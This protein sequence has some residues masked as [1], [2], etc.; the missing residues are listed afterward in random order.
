MSRRVPSLDAP[1]RRFVRQYGADL[2]YW[3]QPKGLAV[4]PHGLYV[5]LAVLKEFAHTRAWR[6]CQAD[7]IARLK[8]EK[9]SG[10][11]DNWTSGGA[12]LARMLKQVLAVLGLAW[13]DLNDRVEITEAGEA[14]LSSKDRVGMLSAQVLRY[15]FWNPSVSS[16]THRVVRLHPVPFLVRLLQSVENNITGV[17]YN[18]FVSKAKC[19]S[20][21][22]RVADQIDAFR[23]LSTSE[24]SEIVLQCKGFSIGGT[25]RSSIYNT[26]NL[27]RAYAY[28]MWTLSNLVI[29]GPD[30]GLQ[31]QQAN[32]RGENRKFLDEY[33]ANGVYIDFASQKEFLSWMG[34]PAERPSKQSA[35]EI[36]VNRGDL[37]SATEVKKELGASAAEIRGFKRMM[38]D[39]KTLE[40]NLE[41]NFSSFGKK[42]GMD[43]TLVGRQYATTV[44]PIDLLGQDKRT[45]Q[46]VV[47]ELKKG[48]SADRVFGQLSR[49]MGWVKRYL[50]DGHAVV[51]VIVAA[52]IDDKLR[53]ARDA[54]DSDVRLLEFESKLSVSVV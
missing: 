40:T 7:Y 39:E 3:Y 48:R 8:Q 29:E 35:L 53:S 2:A 4:T 45:K 52:Q 42:L 50:A 49:Y 21:I 37:S 36:Y 41:H 13:I 44:G 18:L 26:I 9:I 14:F 25:G 38:I 54:H 32:L 19:I 15:Q 16:T 28:K 11:E 20:D 6:D 43:L 47:I 1:W 10:A 24:Q 12:P 30:Y 51:G 22:D 31:L 17:E 23:A 34:N 27:D 5:R 33:A 46:F